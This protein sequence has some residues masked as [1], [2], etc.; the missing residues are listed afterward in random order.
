MSSITFA[1]SLLVF[2]WL[3]DLVAAHWGFTGTGSRPR[4]QQQ[5]AKR[6]MSSRLNGQASSRPP[7]RRTGMRRP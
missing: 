2:A 7:R 6:R 5:P 4:R 3:A 1:L